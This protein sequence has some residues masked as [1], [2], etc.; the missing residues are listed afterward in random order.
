MAADVSKLLRRLDQMKRRRSLIEQ[1]WREGYD[2]TYPIR[3]AMLALSAGGG[4][5]SVDENAAHSYARSQQAKILDGTLAD[6]VRTLASS[7]VSGTTPGNSLWVGY[8]VEGH[9][10]DDLP[11]DVRVWLD[12]GAEAIWKNIHNSNFD[13]VHFECEIDT[14]IPGW[15]VMFADEDEDGGYVFEQWGIAG[16]WAAASKPGG[17]LDTFYREVNLSAEQCVN[18]YG[19]EMVSDNVRRKAEAAPD[20][21]V[22]LVQAIYPRPGPHGQLSVN[23][24]IASCHIEKDTRKL[25]REKGY[26]EHP[27]IAPRWLLVP[28]SV[29][30]LGPVFDALPDAKSLNRA[31]EMSFANMDLAIAGM[32]IAEDDGVLNPRTLKV[33]PRKVV[34]ANS[35]ES[36][37]A[38]EPPG[39]FD[40]AAI[41]VDR[42]QRAIRRVMMADHLEPRAQPGKGG[43][44]APISAT[45]AQI[46]VELTRQLLGPIYGRWLAE[47]V[48]P[49]STRAFGIAYRRGV[50]GQ[51][52]DWLRGKML[53]VK[54]RSPI[55][56]AQQLV[57]VAAMDRYEMT[58]GQEIQAGMTS[59]ADNYD[60]DKA[61]RK[62]AE[63]LAVPSDL[64]VDEDAR[65]AR[66]KQKAAATQQQASAAAG[67]QVAAE[68]MKGGQR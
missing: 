38:L 8:G 36:M 43:T 26:H 32:W 55:A 46:N 20:E 68:A 21:L 31:I 51:P 54:Y 25:V 15:F 14:C 13:A 57:D 61:A 62:R 47:F 11:D 27:I 2:Y 3:G 52:P 34:V 17:P 56:K 24:P 64:I 16:V 19:I 10:D 12:D 33:G 4:N 18:D 35:V 39:K 66:R 50:L 65:D 29:Y 23:L 58:L 9:D 5:T 59:V 6:C 41:E 67:A 44:G 22:T 7:L 30:P 40:L 60:W 37:K 49:L 53:S 42:L 45:E 1:N 48:K 63:L 28:N